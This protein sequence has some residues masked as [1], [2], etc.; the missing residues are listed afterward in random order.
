M[1]RCGRAVRRGRSRSCGGPDRAAAGRRALGPPRHVVDGITLRSDRRPRRG[2]A[3]RQHPWSGSTATTGG[4]GR[5]ST[6]TGAR[7]TAGTSSC[8]S[9]TASRSA[10]TPT[11]PR[12]SPRGGAPTSSPRCWAP[13]RRVRS[14]GRRSSAGSPTRSCRAGAEVPAETQCPRRLE[15]FTHREV[16][17]HLATTVLYAVVDLVADHQAHRVDLCA[18]GDTSAW[19]LRAGGAWEP[20]QPVKNEGTVMYS[21]SVSALPVSPARVVAADAHHGA[22]RRGARAG[23]GRD[24]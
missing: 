16:A 6:A 8:A 10:N 4:S 11:A 13:S 15:E 18:V 23:V 5:T 24:R 19:V 21:S 3:G 22:S 20:L 7:R 12:S 9:P 1:A 2:A 17:D 14:T